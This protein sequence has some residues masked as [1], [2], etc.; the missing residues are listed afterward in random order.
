MLRR[1]DA[2]CMPD[3]WGKN[4]HTHIHNSVDLGYNVMKGTELF[5]V[6]ITEEYHVMLTVTN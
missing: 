2:I 1:K 3:N 5:F 6:V 4:T